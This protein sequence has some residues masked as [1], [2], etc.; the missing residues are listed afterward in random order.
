MAA[1]IAHASIICHY[2]FGPSARE[3]FHVGPSLPIYHTPTN[4]C[5]LKELQTPRWWGLGTNA[6]P[7]NNTQTK[8]TKKLPL[9]VFQWYSIPLVQ[10]EKRLPFVYKERNFI[11][12][13]E[14]RK[15]DVMQKSNRIMQIA[16][17]PS[18]VAV[19]A[20]KCSASI[21]TPGNCC[22]ALAAWSR[23]E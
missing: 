10:R 16:A 6:L 9:D 19:V 2:Q 4:R 17:T 13:G 5:K 7:Q 14:F 15:G 8:K 12:S 21:L 22:I 3:H 20:V 1:P 18:A 23:C 11:V